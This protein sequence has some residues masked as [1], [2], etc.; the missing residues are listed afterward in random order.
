[1]EEVTESFS[2]C[3][4]RATGQCVAHPV[5]G[6]PKATSNAWKMAA[7]GRVERSDLRRFYVDLRRWGELQ[8]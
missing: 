3:L 1:M 7:T 6:A 5:N 4:V 8:I 2:E